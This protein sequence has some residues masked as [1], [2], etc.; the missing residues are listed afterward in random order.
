MRPMSVLAIA[1][2]LYASTSALGD[3][4]D[5]SMSQALMQ[6]SGRASSMTQARF[7]EM[8]ARKP[9][10]LKKTET[11]LMDSLGSVDPRVMKAFQEVPREYFM[12]NYE[13]NRSMA[14]KT[15]EAHPRTWPIGYGSYLSDYRAQAYMTQ[16]AHPKASDVSLEIGT[17][18]GFQSA[19]LSRLVKEAYTVE[20][21]TALGKKVDKIYAPLGYTNV[22][23]R[24]GDGFYGWPGAGRKFNIIIVTCSVPFV[25]PP[26]LAQLSDNGRMIIPIGQPYKT[27]FLYVFTKDAQGRVHSRRD[28][29]TYFI[30]MTGLPPQ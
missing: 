20:I 10:Y 27:Q 18:S 15:Y 14:L 24:V 1:F 2:L 7:A 25:P 12:Y 26:L 19:I 29:P 28:V 5:L 6:E 21:I 3:S 23:A 17:G 13:T 16:L 30:P 9:A 8:E 4:W 11:Y 22:H